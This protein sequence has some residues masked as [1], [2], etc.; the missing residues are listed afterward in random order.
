MVIARPKDRRN[1]E[2]PTQCGGLV[3]L[4]HLTQFS[5]PT[6]VLLPHRLHH[7]HRHPTPSPALPSSSWCLG[8]WFLLLL[9][10]SLHFVPW[11]LHR[12]VRS[13]SP[14]PATSPKWTR[15]RRCSCSMEVAHA[16]A[17]RPLH[18]HLYS[19]VSTLR[20]RHWVL[21]VL[22]IDP[23]PHRKPKQ[24]VYRCSFPVFFT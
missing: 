13:S 6:A 5:S 19:Y 10:S 1:Y 12:T 22:P 14:P 24:S 2:G 18:H 17:S 11:Y 20:L 23:L 8:A 7:L 15:R 16:A 9:L 4:Q 3:F 21:S